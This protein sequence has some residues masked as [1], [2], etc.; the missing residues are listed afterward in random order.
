MTIRYSY[1]KEL[2]H[3]ILETLLPVYCNYQTKVGAK[4]RYEGINPELLAMIKS[5]KR[6]PALL[7]PK[8]FQT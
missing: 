3:L 7:R 8:E 1:T 2:E 5:E 4:D 6:L